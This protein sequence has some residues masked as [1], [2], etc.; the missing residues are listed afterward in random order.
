[1]DRV[2]DDRRVPYLMD[3]IN[4][5]NTTIR[6]LEHKLSEESHGRH[7]LEEE[8]MRLRR[9]ITDTQHRYE[10]MTQRRDL[11]IESLT[12]RVLYLEEELF[13]VTRKPQ[14]PIVGVV[15]DDYDPQHVKD[16]ERHLRLKQE[17]VD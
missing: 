13:N 15:K 12:G 16:L 1:M 6:D 11:E 8:N 7:M 4:L 10:S 2:V 3:D 9:F 17:E 5:K 14:N